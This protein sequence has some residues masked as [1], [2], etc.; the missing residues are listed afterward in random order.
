MG[1]ALEAAEERE[2][3]GAL[4]EVAVVGGALEEADPVGGA[5]EGMAVVGGGN[6]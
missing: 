5:L 3:E 1:S 2:W 6:G 4:E